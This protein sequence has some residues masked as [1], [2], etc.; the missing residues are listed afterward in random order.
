MSRKPGRPEYR[1]NDPDG[2]E[3][4]IMLAQDPDHF[5]LVQTN[6][7]REQFKITCRLCMSMNITLVEEAI[8]DT[9]YTY[10]VCENCGNHVEIAS[11]SEG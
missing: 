1:E 3:R 10:L 5:D 4:F 7:V 11:L 2:P 8:C 6:Y 9:Q